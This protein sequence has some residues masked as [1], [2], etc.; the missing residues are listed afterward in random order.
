MTAPS[1][2][3]VTKHL[4]EMDGI[5]LSLSDV[6]LGTVAAVQAGKIVQTLTKRVEHRVASI[7]ANVRPDPMG[8]PEGIE[9]RQDHHEVICTRAAVDLRTLKAAGHQ[10]KHVKAVLDQARAHLIEDW[11]TRGVPSR[12]LPSPAALRET[13]SK[14]VH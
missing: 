8:L 5:N 11:E 12:V 14:G 4:A 6:Q 1:Q 7:L 3:L 13:L 9:V 2:E 10:A